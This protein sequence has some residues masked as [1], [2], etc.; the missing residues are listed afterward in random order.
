MRI[1]LVENDVTKASELRGSFAAQHL[2]TEIVDSGDDAL[3]LLRHYEYDIVVLSLSLPNGDGSRMIRRI[4]TARLETPILALA[5]RLQPRASIEAFTAGADDVVGEAIDWTELVARMHAIVRRSRGHSQA[6]LR[7]GALTLDVQHRQALA[8]DIALDLTRKEFALL[9]LLMLRKNMVLSKETILSQ[10]YGGLD[11]PEAKI[12]DV[13]V[14]KIRR[15]LAQA[16]LKDVLGTVWGRG[17]TILDTWRDDTPP[18]PIVPPAG[19]PRH[20]A[21][22]MV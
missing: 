8:H 19:E 18:T 13:F 1:L 4:R 10:L 3:E 7:V 21:L 2:K 17:Y 22:A 5:P 16:G 6:K 14:C 9:E 20:R 11:E 12:I 15:K